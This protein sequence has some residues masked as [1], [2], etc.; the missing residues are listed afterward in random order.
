MLLEYIKREKNTLAVKTTP[1]IDQGKVSHFGTVN[2]LK[3]GIASCA[4]Y[5]YVCSTLSNLLSFTYEQAAKDT[6]CEAGRGG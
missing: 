6:G 5:L 4:K 3:T 2:T 1:H